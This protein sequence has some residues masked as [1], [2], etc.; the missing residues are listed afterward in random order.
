MLDSFYPCIVASL[1]A[2][3]FI[4]CGTYFVYFSSSML[5]GVISIVTGLAFV[6]SAY[7]FRNYGFDYG[8]SLFNISIGV[9]FIG[10][11]IIKYIDTK[12]WDK[13]K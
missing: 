8:V 12:Y 2:F 4:T 13:L 9:G 7:V 11:G 10:M 6:A 5:F 1:F 3:F